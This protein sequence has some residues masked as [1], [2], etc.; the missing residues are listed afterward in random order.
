MVS[1]AGLAGMTQQ[2]ESQP[3]ALDQYLPLM[4]Q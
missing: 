1:Q 2:L 4:S 3:T